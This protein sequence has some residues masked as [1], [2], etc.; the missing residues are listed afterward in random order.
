MYFNLG[1]VVLIELIQ[2]IWFKILVLV[3]WFKIFTRDFTGLLELLISMKLIEN[4]LL[5][6]VLLILILKSFKYNLFV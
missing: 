4:V 1:F 2:L 3:S 6:K 5:I